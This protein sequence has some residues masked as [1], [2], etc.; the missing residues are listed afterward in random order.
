MAEPGPVPELAGAVGRLVGPLFAALESL[1]AEVV[2]CRRAARRGHCTER[3]LGPLER[4]IAAGLGE[5]PSMVGLGYVAAPGT[6]GDQQRYLLWW[7]RAG[8]ELAR[9]RLNFDAASVDVYD[10]LDMEWYRAAER[11]GARNAFGPY[12]DYS[13]SGQYVITASVP[14]VDGS[15]FLGVAGADLAMSALEPSLI[16]ALRT[17]PTEVVLVNDEPRVLAANT[18]RWVLGAKLRT[19]APGRDGFVEVTEIPG[20]PGWL[21]ATTGVA[22]P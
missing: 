6:V 4:A 12:V 16:A 1:A 14:V 17:S 18:P 21:L 2:A 22:T 15:T 9:L 10:Y 7:A 8:E 20:G 5:H 13:G 3:D 11:G 19:P